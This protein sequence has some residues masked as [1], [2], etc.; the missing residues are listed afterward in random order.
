MKT[1]TV[2][3][4]CVVLAACSGAAK[5][6]RLPDDSSRVPVNRTLPPEARNGVLK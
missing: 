1:L 4:L 3:V 6:P 5:K 2:W